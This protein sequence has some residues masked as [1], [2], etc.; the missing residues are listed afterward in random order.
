MLNTDSS[1]NTPGPPFGNWAVAFS[2]DGRLLA[3]G[4]RR[5]GDLGMSY[6]AATG[7]IVTADT[8]V[9]RVWLTSPGQVAAD[10]CRT[11]RIPED[12]SENAW[13]TYLP[14]LPYTPACG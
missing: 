7:T 5:R 4:G 12:V 1:P 3:R 2:P 8:H 13:R 14:G 10:I 11:L 6:S 9:T